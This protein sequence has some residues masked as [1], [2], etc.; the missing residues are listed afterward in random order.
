MRFLKFESQKKLI[1]PSL[2]DVDN[3]IVKAKEE[4]ESLQELRDLIVRE[5]DKEEVYT[6][7]F[8]FNYYTKDEYHLEQA[9]GMKLDYSNLTD[10]LKKLGFKKPAQ[11]T[12][13]IGTRKLCEQEKLPIGFGLN[14]LLD[15]I[16]KDEQTKEKLNSLTEDEMVEIECDFSNTSTSATLNFTQMSKREWLLKSLTGNNGLE[17]LIGKDNMLEM[18]ERLK[19]AIKSSEFS[20]DKDKMGEA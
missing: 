4:L 12:I 11:D 8:G 6:S 9:E 3:F 16:L 10:F 18:A 15:N 1:N 14:F 20:F 7:E 2:K 5:A 13:L 17:K 19:K